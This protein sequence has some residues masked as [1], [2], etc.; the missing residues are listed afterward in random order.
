MNAAFTRKSQSTGNLEDNTTKDATAPAAARWLN[1][2]FRSGNMLQ[3][4]G[5]LEQE[6]TNTDRTEQ[7]HSAPDQGDD[8]PLEQELNGTPKNSHLM[9]NYKQLKNTDRCNHKNSD[10]HPIDAP[11]GEPISSTLPRPPSLPSS[12]QSIESDGKSTMSE[13]T[14]ELSQTNGP[15]QSRKNF[16]AGGDSVGIKTSR[17]RRRKNY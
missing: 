14:L 4:G 6:L 16:S 17:Q 8:V 5:N 7:L 1:R 12:I 11:L 9:D 15:L 2:V 10:E 3:I 13:L